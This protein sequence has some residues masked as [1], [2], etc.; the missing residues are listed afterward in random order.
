MLPQHIKWIKIS[1]PPMIQILLPFWTRSLNSIWYPTSCDRER[2]HWTWVTT[3]V[4]GE[5]MT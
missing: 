2:L 1:N 3:Q 4:K 5:K